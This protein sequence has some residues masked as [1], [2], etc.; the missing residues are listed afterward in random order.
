MERSEAED[1]LY[2]EARM[3]DGGHWRDWQQLFTE[4]AIYWIPANRTDCDPD[5]HVSYIYDNM[6]LLEERLGRLESGQCYAQMPPSVTLHQVGNVLVENS[7]EDQVTLR[8]N[9]ILHE[10]RNNTQRRFYP[11]QTFPAECE[12]VLEKQDGEWKIKFK[13]VNLLNCD[14]EIVDLTFLV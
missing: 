11:L 2:T 5:L 3:L 8:S 12:H 13:K 10:F 9:L 7:G 1:F 6:D 4:D 14:G